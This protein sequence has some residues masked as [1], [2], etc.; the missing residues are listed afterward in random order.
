MTSTASSD[1]AAAHRRALR[2]AVGVICMETGFD[3]ANDSCL[4]S[5]TEMLQSYITELGRS[6]RNYCELASRTLPM[7]TDVGMALTG[8]GSSVRGLAHYARRRRRFPPLHQDRGKPPQPCKPLQTN[9]RKPHPSYIPDHLPEFPD[10]HTYI[11]TATNRQQENDY[12]IIRE[13]AASQKRDV[14]R[15]LTRFIAKT[16]DTQTLFPGDSN[17]FPLIA[18]TP[19]PL[20]YVDA[21][22][23]PEHEICDE[24]EMEDTDTDEQK[25]ATEEAESG[26]TEEGEVAAPKSP[27]SAK[28]R[29]ERMKV[30]TVLVDNPFLRKVKKPR[31]K[32]KKK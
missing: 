7:V 14:E 21:L 28:P 15:A 19:S 2:V 16:G 13:R 30:E 9:E 5:L 8:M 22:M 3:C 17:V 11:R 32:V 31:L 10:P 26:K 24:D 12:K 25:P 6:A 29:V 1:L 20:P 27:G 23:P 4:E 18:C